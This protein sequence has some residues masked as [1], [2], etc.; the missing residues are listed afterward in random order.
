MKTKERYDLV[1]IGGGVGGRSGAIAG[2]IYG[3]TSDLTGFI[4]SLIVKIAH[5]VREN[6]NVA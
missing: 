2:D 1:V 4:S 5:T 3:Q 6:S